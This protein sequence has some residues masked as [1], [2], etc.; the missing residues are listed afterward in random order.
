MFT[1]QYRGYMRLYNVKLIDIVQEG[2]I[3]HGI[4][5]NHIALLQD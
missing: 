2:N 5:E 3:A 4:Q 1:I